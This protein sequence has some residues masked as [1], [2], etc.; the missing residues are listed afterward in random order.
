MADT[1]IFRSQVRFY[2]KHGLYLEDLTP[3]TDMAKDESL[4]EIKRQK[5]LFKTVVDIYIVA[6]LI[7]YLYGRTAQ[8][9]GSEPTKNIMEGALASH[10]DRLIFSYE[11]LM[12]LDEKDEPDLNERIRMAFRATDELAKKGVDIYDAYARGGI[13]VLHE[14]L[15]DSSSD[16]EDLIR[17]T[18]K[19]V[20]NFNDSFVLQPEEGLDYTKV[21]NL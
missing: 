19:F 20:D 21:L 18:M 3:D 13:E 4:P 6:P 5:L 12:I 16:T 17:S 10:Q 9:D 1:E 11:L 8:K 7:G 14:N 15:I 2:G